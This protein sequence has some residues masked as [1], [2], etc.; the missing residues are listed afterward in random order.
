MAASATPLASTVPI[1]VSLSPSPNAARKSCAI[2]PRWSA[3]SASA[4]YSQVEIGSELT[5]LRM[6]STSTGAMFSLTLM[7]DELTWLV[8]VEVPVRVR[9]PA[10][11]SFMMGE[12]GLA[13]EAIASGLAV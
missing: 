12:P 13:S 11:L 4:M 9:S 1:V 2:G 10:V 7:S 6:A 3:S 5:P 8:A